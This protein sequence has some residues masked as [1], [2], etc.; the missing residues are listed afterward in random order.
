MTQKVYT[1]TW[2]AYYKAANANYATAHG[3]ATGILYLSDFYISNYLAAG[4]YGMA[5]S[6]FE[7]DQSADKIPSTM[8]IN[9]VVINFKSLANSNPYGWYLD[10]VTAAGVVPGS[11]S[12]ACFHTL[13][14]ATT[15]YGSLLDSLCTGDVNVT[16]NAA[17]IADIQSQIAS[18]PN[19]LL[20]GVRHSEDIANTLPTGS[21]GFTVIPMGVFPI[22]L[23]PT[24]TVNYSIPVPL[25]G[26]G[27]AFSIPKGRI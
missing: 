1:N 8:I 13:L 21:G 18:S 11:E 9:S 27:P 10:I 12:T 20:L 7:F 4:L 3:A 5:R 16:L 14:T 15:V 23:R 17:G 6:F 2:L 25:P 24:I 26:I 19:Y 22:D